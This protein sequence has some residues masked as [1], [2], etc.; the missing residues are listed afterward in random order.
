MDF[1]LFMCFWIF[2]IK[3]SKDRSK[4]KHSKLFKKNKNLSKHARTNTKKMA[5]SQHIGRIDAWTCSNAYACV[6]FFTHMARAFRVISL[7]DWVLELQFSNLM[8]KFSKQEVMVSIIFIISPILDSASP[9]FDCLRFPLPFLCP[10][11][12]WELPFF[13]ARSLWQLGL[14]CPQIPQWWQKC[15]VYGPLCDFARD[16]LFSLSLA[17]TGFGGFVKNR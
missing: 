9:L 1:L 17:T 6:P 13:N 2:D 7:E 15:W 16:F 10:L 4:R 3:E 14:V 12:L 8:M 11:G 5:K